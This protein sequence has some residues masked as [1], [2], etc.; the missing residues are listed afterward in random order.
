LRV[1][2]VVLVSGLLAAAFGAP[3]RAQQA[4]LDEMITSALQSNLALKR[5]EAKV[6]KA[7]GD[8]QEAAGAF[9]WTPM[10]QTGWERLY[11]PLA[12]NGVLTTG[13]DTLNAWRTT[14]SI[15]RVFRNGIEVEPGVTF[16]ENTGGVTSGQSLGQTRTLPSLKLKIPLLQ[17]L[18][19][20]VADAE[21]RAAH[22]GLEASRLHHDFIEQ[23]VIHDTVQAFWKCLALA[24]QQSIAEVS[25]RDVADYEAWLRS[26][27]DRGQVEPVA[28]QRAEADK[29]NRQV[30]LSHGAE[31]IDACHRDLLMVSGGSEDTLPVPVGEMPVPDKI[32]PAIDHLNQGALVDRALAQRLDL[33]ALELIVE[34]QTGRVHAAENGLLPKVDVFI[35]PN[36]V[37]L[38]YTQHLEND[39]AHG[40]IS[41]AEADETLAKL[42]LAELR[43]RIK[44][45]VADIVRQ[46]RLAWQ[47]WKTLSATETSIEA[48]VAT[49]EKQV[50]A[51]LIGR[52]QLLA[53]Q[54]VLTGIRHQRV[55]ARLQLA[56][57]LATLRLAV[58]AIDFEGRAP[59][60]IAGDFQ[61]LPQP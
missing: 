25:G 45:D 4:H 55:E 37:F 58:G 53:T 13:T 30:Q 42:D 32:G 35:D 3:S 60:A 51:G 12:Q 41:K 14:T 43:G 21:E 34:A 22:Q 8:E 17:G 50:K 19:E 29:T 9:D 2:V 49:R 6:L 56:S 46:L 27:T 26:M 31:A 52:D 59:A 48:S 7:S 18:G 61:A 16:Y 33:K 47:N 36:K 1:A 20:E 57:T 11:L 44:L 40:R 5:E 24:D 15:G 54:D 10:A 28:E 23:Q 38:E 39:L